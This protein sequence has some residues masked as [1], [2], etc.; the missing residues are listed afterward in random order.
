MRANKLMTTGTLDRAAGVRADV[1]HL[2]P[3]WEVFKKYKQTGVRRGSVQAQ[4]MD[5]TYS[6]PWIHNQEEK[7]HNYFAT[8]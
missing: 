2:R 4:P 3:E 1:Y 6:K 5:R 8:R 7:Q